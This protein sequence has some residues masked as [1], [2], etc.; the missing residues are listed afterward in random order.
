[1]NR[2]DKFKFSKRSLKRLN[3]VHPDLVTLA[4]EG[5]RSTPYDFGIT[6]GVRTVEQQ[7]ELY[8][9]GR[10][11]PGR[12]VT[13]TM[14]SKHLIQPDGFS[15]AFDIAV[16][17]GGKLTWTEKYYDVVGKHLEKVAK[18]LDIPMLWG[19]RFRRRKDRPHFE[20]KKKH[21]GFLYV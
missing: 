10:T 16:W 2:H 7:R 9:K 20:L 18:D 12:K 3:G 4:K 6:Q 13:W 1:M 17:I 21:K 15:H 11:E 5:I 8:A 19:G 14:N